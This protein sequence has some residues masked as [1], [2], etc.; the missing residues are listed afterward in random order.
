MLCDGCVIA[1]QRW[2]SAWKSSNNSIGQMRMPSTEYYR[3]NDINLT[4]STIPYTIRHRP[5]CHLLNGISQQGPHGK[6]EG[7]TSILQCNK[8]FSYQ[9]LDH[10]NQVH[11]KSRSLS[12]RSLVDE[13]VLQQGCNIEAGC[14]V[15]FKI[16]FPLNPNFE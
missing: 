1:H 3:P 6:H 13:R 9:E 4:P 14:L 5:K 2:A 7:N 15:L 16:N 8:D 10:H 12:A 11:G